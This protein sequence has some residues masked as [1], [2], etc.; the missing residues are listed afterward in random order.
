MH[1]KAFTT[2]EFHKVKDLIAA[3]AISPMAKELILKL[4]PMDDIEDVNCALKETTEA[5]NLILKYGVVPIRGIHDI[6]SIVKRLEVGGTLSIVELM[7][8]ADVLRS[9]KLAKSYYNSG[10]E[11]IDTLTI[12]DYLIRLNPIHTLY[13]EITRCILS[14]EEV[15]DDASSELLRI[16]REIKSVNSKI[17]TALN[18]IVQSASQSGYLQDNL[19]TMRNDRYCLP[20]K[21]EYRSQ[22]K[23]MIHDQSSTG[24]TLFI[25]PLAV[26][27]LNNSLST[28]FSDEKKEIQKILVELS[29]QAQAHKET[30]SENIHLLTHLDFIM[31]KAHYSID[32]KCSCPEFNDTYDIYL[33]KARHP[34]LDPKTVVPTT[35]YL[36]KDFTT[37]VVTGPNTGGKTVTLKTLGLL[38]IMGQSGL[39]IPAFDGARLTLLDHVFADIG[40]EQSIEQSLSTFSSH[41]TNITFILDHVTDRSLVLFDE[42]GAGTDPVEG[43]ALAMAILENLKEAKILTAA[44]THYS[45]LKVYALTTDGVEN[46]S[47]EFD[48]NTLRPTYKLLIGIPGKSNAFAISKRLGLSDYIIDA[49][50][51]FLN[52]HAVRFEDLITDLET[53]RKVALME[54]DRAQEYRKEAEQ[55]KGEIEEQRS[56]LATQKRRILEEAKTDALRLLENAKGEADSIIKKMNDLVKSGTG[57]NMADLEEQRSAIR[58]KLKDSNTVA[59]RSVRGKKGFK[60]SE[61]AVGDLVYVTSLNQKG[62]IIALAP[63]KKEATVQIGIMKSKV[64]YDALDTVTEEYTDSPNYDS[65]HPTGKKFTVAKGNGLVSSGPTDRNK[66]VKTELDLRGTNTSEA[67]ELVDK[68]LDDAYLAHLSQVTLIHGKG[69]GVLRQNIHQFLRTCSQ[70][71][72]YR[73]GNFGEGDSGV[74]I[75]EFND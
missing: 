46:A 7:Y 16:R 50:K 14:E 58:E 47:C 40:D 27:E 44:T 59:Q 71:K 66:H 39:H 54:K 75:V 60:P 68:Y 73:L 24:S 19:I 33:E 51:E 41:M 36:G 45:E 28:L 20:V 29:Q 6:R 26:V 25:E 65:K 23:G 15:A 61:L 17:K 56:R 8:V 74:T 13:T 12:S 64:P 9:T 35:I 43:A 31:S 1:Q 63:Q 62:T 38:S 18:R 4:E 42:L 11:Y 55:L 48:V 37:L 22:F 72:A 5:A 69:T 10:K 53:N 52:G 2:L 21:S 70:V 34:L 67:L 49:A 57:L 3:K 32:T 30:L